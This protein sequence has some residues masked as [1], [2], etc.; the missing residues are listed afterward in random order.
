MNDGGRIEA[1]SAAEKNRAL[2]QAHI[3]FVVKAIAALRAQRCD[4]AKRFPGAQRG[5]RNPDAARD[6]ADSQVTMRP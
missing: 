1:S 6:F 4:E 3:G 5:R 2:E